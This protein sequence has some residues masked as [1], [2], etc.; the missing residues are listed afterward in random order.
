M[1]K[2]TSV[3]N[4]SLMGLSGLAVLWRFI[5]MIR[6]FPIDAK[7]TLR[8]LLTAPLTMVVYAVV[9]SASLITPIAL[10]MLAGGAVLGLLF[11]LFTRVRFDGQAVTGKRASFYLI[12]WAAAMFI[13]QWLGTAVGNGGVSA[14]LT[15]MLLPLGMG[16]VQDIIV[17]L[18]ASAA[19][20]RRPPAAAT[21]VL[22]LALL[23]TGAVLG[24]A[25][26]RAAVTWPGEDWSRAAA[27][28]YNRN[29]HGLALQLAQTS[30]NYWGNIYNGDLKAQTQLVGYLA[31]TKL[32]NG[33]AEVWLARARATLNRWF[34][35]AG[36]VG[37]LPTMIDSMITRLTGQILLQRGTDYVLRTG[38][39]VYAQGLGAVYRQDIPELWARY[40]YLIEKYRNF[41]GVAALL[42]SLEP[43]LQ[44]M[45]DSKPVGAIPAAAAALS[46]PVVMLGSTVLDMRA[47]AELARRR[48]GTVGGGAGGGTATTSPGSPATAKDTAAA[49]AAASQAALQQLGAASAHLRDQLAGAVRAGADLPISLTSWQP[50]KPGWLDL[51][52]RAVEMYQENE[53][54]VEAAKDVRELI[55]EATAADG[56]AELAASRLVS[57]A[58]FLQER[59]ISPAD[60]LAVR[61]E[62]L[63]G[64]LGSAGVKQVLAAV[65]ATGQN[66]PAAA[67]ALDDAVRALTG[68]A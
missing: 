28:E 47:L 4:W 57:A 32:Q 22:L 36:S 12:L 9:L 41:P 60:R 29:N 44:A 52:R 26:A 63:A 5:V 15:L 53:D 64:R 25:P 54:Q 62:D 49:G 33:E 17:L 42:A 48:A 68:G 16:A 58:R 65:D 18:K 6:P 55:G 10:Y 38:D 27:I 39:V 11:G 66:L 59:G 31:S 23:V 46:V 21:A 34:T 24:A 56:L 2:M 45:A 50:D 35:E 37:D 43:V 3:F 40:G 7:A 14:G 8:G 61:I 67:S 51:V 1:T 13:T 20:G 19:R 30:E